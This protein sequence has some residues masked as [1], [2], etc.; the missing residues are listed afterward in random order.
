MIGEFCRRMRKTYYARSRYQW[1]LFLICVDCLHHDARLSPT[2]PCQ[3]VI[4]DTDVFD[5]SL[6]K[7]SKMLL[8]FA[9]FFHRLQWWY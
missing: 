9:Q 1:R 8:I 4:R 7:R 2:W 6:K 3:V 5:L